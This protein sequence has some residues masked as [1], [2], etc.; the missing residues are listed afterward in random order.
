MTDRFRW[1]G[2]STMTRSKNGSSGQTL[3][4]EHY[5]SVADF[6][7]A[8]VAEWIATGNA[9]A[10]TTEATNTVLVVQSAEVK[11]KSPKI[12]KAN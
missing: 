12:G 5:Y 3:E 2:R 11:L 1:T 6:S 9:E 7:A 10:V 8:V 4:P